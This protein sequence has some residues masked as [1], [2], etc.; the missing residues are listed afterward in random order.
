MDEDMVIFEMHAHMCKVMGHVIRLRI[1]HL[2]KDGPKCVSDITE[3]LGNTTQPTVSRH[4]SILKS[5]GILSTHREGSE[6]IYE[7]A[8]PKIIGVCETMRTIIAERESQ[9]IDFFQNYGK[10]KE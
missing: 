10:E 9:Y 6:S 1:V 2:L 3:L 5:A 7:I 4:L 8:N